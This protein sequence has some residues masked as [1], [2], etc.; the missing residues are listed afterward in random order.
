MSVAAALLVLSVCLVTTLFIWRRNHFNYFKKLGIPG[1]TPNW[2]WGN[3]LE[4]HSM[5]SYKVVGKWIEEYGSVF[6]FF[7]GDV[8]FVVL[9]DLDFIEYV[10]VRNFRNFVDRGM[11]PQLE[12]DAELF[13]KSLEEYADTNA[14]IHML[15][16]FEELTMDYTARG[17]FGME[18]HFQGNPD[19]PLI[20]LSR[21][22]FRG[23]IKGPLH[24]IGQC[25]TTIG[26][27][28][29]PFYWFTTLVGEFTFE[30]LGKEIE[31][32]IEMRKKDPSL[33][34]SDILQSLI[35][36]EGTDTLDSNSNGASKSSEL[37]SSAVAGTATLVFIGG[38]DSTAATLSYIAFAL[39]KYPDIQ[40]R[41]REEVLEA[42]SQTGTLNYEI[43]MQKLKYLG[44]VVDETLRLYPP[45]LL[46][47]TRKAK[48]DF[49][50]KGIKYKAG[51]CFVVST[52]HLHTNP[53]F[54]PNAEQFYPERF[55]PENE[56]SLKKLA[57]APFGIG[58]RNC[59]GSKLALMMV[60]YTIAKFVQKY[61]LELGESQM[62]S[63]ELAARSIVSAPGRGPWIKLYRA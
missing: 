9:N 40:E 35:D 43:I 62:G 55:A 48:G 15:P 37:S 58:P 32:V 50:Y 23:I 5:E 42:L 53:Q 28:M 45:G 19:H 1:P 25:T 44:Y 24:M 51:T 11:V 39:A 29:K 6:G 20:E 13:T 26:G 61:R 47:V 31:K 22:V 10:Y 56:A 18:E 57:Y 38:F 12:E 36:A 63:M 49:E 14:E 59:V 34:K 54:W 41:V 27:W 17:A 16:K 60:K 33:R 8:P 3:L 4:Y 2:I 7:N 21:T 52:Y 30:N 46:S